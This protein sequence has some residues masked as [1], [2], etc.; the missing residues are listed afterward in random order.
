[1]TTSDSDTGRDSV[2]TA[3]A[4]PLPGRARRRSTSP[5]TTPRRHDMIRLPVARPRAPAPVAS[6]L[7]VSR[8][9]LVRHRDVPRFL[10]DAV[11]LRRVFR[12]ADGGAELRLAAEPLAKT[13]WTYSLWSSDGSMQR[14]VRDPLHVAVMARYADRM[15][16]SQFATKIVDPSS[17]PAATSAW[18]ELAADAD[19]RS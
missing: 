4:K 5:A 17:P 14:Y 12:H 16:A 13:F 10:I 15:A 11:R 2:A 6:V 19:R 1:M 8:L 7:L 18:Q 3:T 9:E